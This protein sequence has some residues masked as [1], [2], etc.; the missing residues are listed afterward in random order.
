MNDALAKK[1]GLTDTKGGAVVTRVTPK[2]PADKAMLKVG[3]VI[4][5]V[6]SK[7][8]NS[9]EEAAAELA[10]QDVSKGVRFYV[11]NAGGARFVFVEP[12]GN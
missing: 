2:S 10:K 5:K 7:T 12:A 4:T 8:V 6:G 1:F 9:A 11:T 3:D